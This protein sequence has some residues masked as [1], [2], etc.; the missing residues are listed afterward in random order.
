[1]ARKTSD[2]SYM[3]ATD[4]HHLKPIGMGR[5]R[6]GPLMEHYLAVRL[7]R[8]EHRKAEKPVSRNYEL[9]YKMW[10]RVA[11]DLAQ[12]LWEREQ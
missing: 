7:T 11:L 3:P 4:T 10:K 5:D 2:V 6:K 8:E 1:M 9:H 12:E